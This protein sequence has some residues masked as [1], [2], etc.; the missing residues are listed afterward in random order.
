M[1]LIS[2]EPSLSTLSTAIPS[3]TSSEKL[4]SSRREEDESSGENSEK[5]IIRKSGNFIFFCH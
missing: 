1:L 4:T 3:D 5:I 2:A